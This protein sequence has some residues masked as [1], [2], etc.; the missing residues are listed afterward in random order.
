MTTKTVHAY[1]LTQR[2]IDAMKK[3]GQ[4]LPLALRVRELNTTPVVADRT[5]LRNATAA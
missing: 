5:D 1:Q 3:S 2:Q 4:K